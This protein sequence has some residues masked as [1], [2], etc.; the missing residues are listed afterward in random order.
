MPEHKTEEKIEE[1]NHKTSTTSAATEGKNTKGAS[2]LDAQILAIQ[3]KLK[4]AQETFEELNKMKVDLED[5]KKKEDIKTK[6]ESEKEAL[7]ISNLQKENQELKEKISA[8]QSEMDGLKSVIG[9]LKSNVSKQAEEFQTRIMESLKVLEDSKIKNNTEHLDTTPG[10]VEVKKDSIEETKALFSSVQNEPTKNPEKNEETAIKESTI[11]EET[12]STI[13]E[14]TAVTG[15]E[16]QA[17]IPVNV[18]DMGAD[19]VEE[20]FSDFDRIKQ[21]L[22]NLEKEASA[23]EISDDAPKPAEEASKDTTTNIID[24]AAGTKTETDKEKSPDTAPAVIS[25][26][27]KPADTDTSATDLAAAESI[28][29]ILIQ[30]GVNPVDIPSSAATNTAPEKDKPKKGIVKKILALIM[31]PFKLVLKLFTLIFEKSKNRKNKKA[32]TKAAV[33]TNEIEADK[34]EATGGIPFIKAAVFLLAI[35]AAGFIYQVRNAKKTTEMYVAQVKGVQTT[36]SG[37]N[38]TDPYGMAAT[39]PEKRYKEAFAEVPFDKT[40]WQVYKDTDYGITVTYPQNTSH[41]LKPMGSENIWFLRQ[42]G[43]LMSIDRIEYAKSLDD[44][45]ASSKMTAKYGVEKVVIKGV[46]A[47]KLVLQEDLAV[48]GNYFI[49]KFNQHIYRIWY[50]TYLPGENS[51]DEKRVQEMI[52]SIEFISKNYSS[53]NSSNR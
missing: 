12:K 42:D 47:I 17:Q 28:N 15:E 48:K 16:K 5:L 4:K 35:F 45:F 20:D 41:R 29:K 27:V 33:T 34:V 9:S 18:V 44:F 13:G 14:E 26:D 10:S 31:L 3:D 6:E 23:I 30:A 21:E 2:N 32:D 7:N 19:V 36:N 37:T 24:L 11:G 43:Y 50:R 51:D 52:N 1:G 8:Y 38:K 49:A 46:P 25:N 39:D 40:I 22:L 53:N